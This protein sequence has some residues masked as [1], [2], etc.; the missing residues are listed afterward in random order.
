MYR[1]KDNTDLSKLEKYGY[2][3]E[4]GIDSYLKVYFPKL[5]KLIPIP[6]SSKVRGLSIHNDGSIIIKKKYGFCWIPAF[7]DSF[8]IQDLIDAGLV[9]GVQ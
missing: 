1:L 7:E 3:Y 6:Y 4:S 2:K 8:A 9:E 5:L